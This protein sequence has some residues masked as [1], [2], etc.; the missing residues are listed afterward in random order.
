MK[1][2]S[3]YSK[4]SDFFTYP[5]QAL[6]GPLMCELK[7][8]GCSST[9]TASEVIMDGTTAA[10]SVKQNVDDGFEVTVCVKCSNNH[11]AV[12]HDNWKIK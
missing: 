2:L 9:S 1:P 5:D 6:C 10:V 7:S 8:V 12:T 11:K 4:V 3:S